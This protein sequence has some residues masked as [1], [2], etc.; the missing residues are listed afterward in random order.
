MILAAAVAVLPLATSPPVEFV[1]E[2]KTGVVFPAR[3]GGMSL[4]GVGVRTKTFLRVKIYA[5]GFY[6]AD[7]A[8]SGPLT[9]HR[10]TV[11]TAQFYR[12]LVTGDFEKQLVLKLVRD[13]SA[14]QIQGAFRTQMR[15]AN[16]ELLDRFLSY[17]VGTKAGQECVLRWAPGGVLETSVAG[18]VKTPIPD[19]AFSQAVFAV[20]LG[21][22]KA[23]DAP[24]RGRLVSRA[25]ELLE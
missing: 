22:D 23:V 13:L 17:F 1:K 20:W 16:R 7:S 19:R 4:F 8:I 24:F 10:G 3:V 14:E 21:D 15:S 5:I 18:V 11:G 9:V 25:G 2:P 12:D 6:V